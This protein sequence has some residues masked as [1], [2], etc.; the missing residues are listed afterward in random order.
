VNKRVDWSKIDWQM[1]T[2]V[3]AQCMQVQ[4]HYVSHFRRIHA[5]DTLAPQSPKGHHP[6][7]LWCRFS[8][9]QKRWLDNRAAKLGVTQTEVIRRAVDAAMKPT[10]SK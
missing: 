9:K 3:I 1:K 4:P 2:S 8:P 10:V 5:P 6:E 7:Q